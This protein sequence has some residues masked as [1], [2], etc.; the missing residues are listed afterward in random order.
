MT[1]RA[2]P[3]VKVSHGGKA[4]SGISLTPGPLP[5]KGRGNSFRRVSAPVAP[6][7][8]TGWGSVCHFIIA[9]SHST[10]WGKIMHRAN[11]AAWR[12]TNGTTER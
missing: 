10:I 7:I 4:A 12:S 5:A 1:A 3:G 11:P 9:G 8:F 6:T 2:C